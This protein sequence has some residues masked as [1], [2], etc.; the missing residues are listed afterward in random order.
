MSPTNT[1]RQLV[2]TVSLLRN[3]MP[4]GSTR[5]G[6]VRSTCHRRLI[7]GYGTLQAVQAGEIRSGSAAPGKDG[8]PAPMHLWRV[9][10][11]QRKPTMGVHLQRQVRGSELL[12]R[13]TREA[14]VL[15]GRGELKP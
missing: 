15:F 5:H 13:S 8:L 3:L 14:F 12:R 1:L 4:L 7:G 2:K 11:V 10:P 6:I 9:R